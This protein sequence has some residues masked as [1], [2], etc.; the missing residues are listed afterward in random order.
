MLGGDVEV[1]RQFSA[2]P[3]DHLIFTGSTGVGR[4][5]MQAAA[6]NLVP[7]TLELG[8]K[9]PVIIGQGVNLDAAAARIVHGK[10]LNCG[11]ICVSPDYLLVPRAQVDAF[12]EAAK[13]AFRTMYPQDAVDNDDYTSVV[14]SRHAARIHS[15]LDDAKRR[16][17]QV[18]ACQDGAQGTRIPLHL[19]LG[20]T[21]EMQ[22]A[23]EEIFGPVLPI[24]PYDSLDEA[25]AYI[26]QGP[27][28]LAMYYF[29]GDRREEKRLRRE[30]HAG[31]MTINDW[32][33]H[34]MQSDL[35][36]G[37]IGDSGMG[38]Y[39]GVEGFRALSHGKSV[40]RERRWFPVQLFH[41]PYGN[42]VQRLVTR[43]YLGPQRDHRDPG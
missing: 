35:P 30:T 29:G 22:L 40:F 4:Q 14:S 28:P 42:L 13:R 11:Q 5:V 2:L 7:V 10:A 19:V 38:S 43:L 31:G 32:A 37:G 15:M 3:F 1:G 34:V 36:F 24:L 33:W 6:A 9:S 25:I 16:G 21:P 8:G 39:H 12:V 17:A 23:R 26:N 41:P 18:V 27:R 20:L